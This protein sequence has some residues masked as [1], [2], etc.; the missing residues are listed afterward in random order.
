MTDLSQ[1][2]C[3]SGW[4]RK[5]SVFPPCVKRPQFSLGTLGSLAKGM[6]RAILQQLRDEQED[7]DLIRK[8]WEKTL[9]EV[10]LGYIWHDE[11]ADPMKFFLQKGLDWFSEPES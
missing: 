11:N 6:N 5:T 1:G 2:F 3:I 9:E 8:T 4:Q 10:E 7:E